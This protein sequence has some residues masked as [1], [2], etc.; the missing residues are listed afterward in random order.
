MVEIICLIS[1][2]IIMFGI[3][4]IFDARTITKKYFSSGDEN[5][6]AKM[7]KVVG[8]VISLIGAGIIYVAV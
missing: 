2:L 8:L 5:T 4:I 6:V 3:V 7:L 1:A